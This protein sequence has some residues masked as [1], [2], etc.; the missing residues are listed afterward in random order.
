MGLDAMQR[1]KKNVKN[2]NSCQ[3]NVMQ[4]NIVEKELSSGRKVSERRGHRETDAEMIE[5]SYYPYIYRRRR[6]KSN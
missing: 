2:E 5:K 4:I 6:G 3:T 1:Y